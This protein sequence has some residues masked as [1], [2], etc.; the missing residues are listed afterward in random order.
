[1]IPTTP[2]AWV[3]LV[4]VVGLILPLLWAT[5]DAARY[6]ASAWREAGHSKL[7]WVALLAFGTVAIF[8]G[9][10]AFFI[11]GGSIRAEVRRCAGLGGPEPAH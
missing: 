8:V 6:P 7:G 11:Y 1:L 9:F 3:A 2:G 5:L 10:V 4:L